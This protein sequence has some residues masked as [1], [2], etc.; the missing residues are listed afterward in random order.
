MNLTGNILPFM[1]PEPATELE[2]ER[3]ALR[4]A[5]KWIDELQQSDATLRAELAAARNALKASQACSEG[6]REQTDEYGDKLATAREA[7]ET[8][9]RENAHLADGE[10]CTLAPVKRALA[11]ITHPP[12]AEEEE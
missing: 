11:A 1:K 9:L 2:M 7:L 5:L 8:V 4:E 3:L 12:A 6:Y 10:V